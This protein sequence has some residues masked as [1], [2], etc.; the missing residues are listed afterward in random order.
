M[1]LGAI[2]IAEVIADNQT[3]SIVDMTDNNIRT[4][5]LM[6]I[7]LSMKHN[8][9]VVDLKVSDNF[10]SGDDNEDSFTNLLEE[11]KSYCALNESNP[12]YDESFELL[13]TVL[14]L[15]IV[16]KMI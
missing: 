13:K 11:L 12:I 7:C 5:G 14:N 4:A 9:S 10:N 2:A 6:A 16:L 3:I 1:I 15:K 8:T